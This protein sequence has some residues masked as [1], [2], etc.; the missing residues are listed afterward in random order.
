MEKFKK[1]GKDLERGNI[2]EYIMADYLCDKYNWTIVKRNNDIRYDFMLMT[3]DGIKTY[4]VKTDMYEFY[5]GK[6][7][8]NMIFETRC[9]GKN[10]GVSATTA[11]YFIYYLPHWRMAYQI[12]VSKLRE[13]MNSRGDLFRKV[14]KMGD[15]GAASGYIANRFAVMSFFDIHY[16]K[17]RMI[18]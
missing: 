9:R 2:G 3:D 6:I 13:L 8:N 18:F 17:K 12:E 5:T 10:S 16:F 11:D 14:N 1:F 7:T 15:D 4:E